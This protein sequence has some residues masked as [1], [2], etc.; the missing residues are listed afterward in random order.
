MML[1]LAC[2]AVLA[3]A[4]ALGWRWRG[5]DLELPTWATREERGGGTA[6]LALVWLTGVG[7]STGLLVGALV[8]GPA[9]RLVMRLLAAT[10]PEAQGRITE[11]DQVVGRI[12]FEGTVGFVVFVGLPF[13]V[14]MG[15][16][17]AFAHV[18]LPRGPAGGALLGAAALVVF[19]STV[20]PLREGNPDFGLVGPGW[21]AVLTFSAMALLCGALTAPFAGRVGSALSGPRRWWIAWMLPLDL[22]LVAALAVAPAA[23]AVVVVVSAGFV[24]ALSVPPARRQVVWRRGRRALQVALAAAVAVTAPGFVSAAIGIVE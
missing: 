20:D 6:M 16:L 8:V 19:G 9:G 14:V 5:C 18:C 17:Y 11:A 1:M 21:L 3:A 24:A 23:L 13:G 22:L 12:T 10:S 15:L 4:V 7:I 2:A